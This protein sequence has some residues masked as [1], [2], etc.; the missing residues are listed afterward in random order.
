MLAGISLFSST[1][2]LS[3]GLSMEILITIKPRP[4]LFY[5]LSLHS[6]DSSIWL[7][8]T[9]AHDISIPSTSIAIQHRSFTRSDTLVMNIL[10]NSLGFS[11]KI[12]AYL[13]YRVHFNAYFSTLKLPCSRF[14][15]S[16]N[17]ATLNS[18]EKKLSMKD[19]LKVSH[20]IEPTST[21]LES[22]YCSYQTLDISFNW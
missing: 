1:P 7:A 8:N 12:G 2:I 5:N 4:L 18:L 10:I 9:I 15:N 17:L 6:L 19:D 16:S 21:C 11:T 13:D 3:L 20:S 22:F 14:M